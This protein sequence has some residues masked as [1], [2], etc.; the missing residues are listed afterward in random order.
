MPILLLATA[1]AIGAAT[2][3]AQ[4]ALLRELAVAFGGHEL[5][6]ALGLAVWVGGTA[7]GAG[8]TPAAIYPRRPS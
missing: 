8:R 6:L 4:L 7:W 5:L 3:L 2:L 1:A